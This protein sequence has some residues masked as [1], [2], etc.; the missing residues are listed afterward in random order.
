MDIPM[1]LYNSLTKKVEDFTPIS[2]PKVSLYVCGVT[3]YDYCHLGH[4]RAYVAFDLLKRVLTHQGYD[5][6]HVQNVTDIDD[7]IIDR[8]NEQGE[9]IHALTERFTAACNEDL[10]ALNILPANHMPK[11]TTHIPDMIRLI[12]NLIQKD[13]A[14]VIN[15]SVYFRIKSSLDYG[16]LSH[17]AIDDLHS[18][19][20][21]DVDHQKES[22]LDFVLWKPAKPDEPHWD[23]P[24]GMG[25][26]GW[27]SE[28]VAM[29]N[30]IL[31]PH[32]DIHGG[33]ADLKFPHHENELAQAKC[34][35][36]TP[37][38]NVWVHNGFVTI[39]NEKMSKSLGNFFTLR[40]IFNDHSPDAVRFFLMRTHYR[41]PLQYSTDA[42]LDATAAYKKLTSVFDIV[43][44]SPIPSHLT[45]LFDGIKTRFWGALSHDLNASEAI[46]HLFEL[47]GLI[48]EYQCG[49]AL[50]HELGAAIGLFYKNNS[51][52]PQD[53]QSMAEARWTAKKAKNFQAA[54]ELRSQIEMAGYVVEDK[55]DGYRVRT[56]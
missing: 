13:A 40:D 3:V 53:I 21:I 16:E 36:H 42:L 29:V 55:P 17:K 20:R 32:I 49:T 30:A 15:N 8:A 48:H 51:E 18:G 23:S 2:P 47:H 33:G 5:V 37:F 19:H 6:V 12:Q 52:I 28:C 50:L 34:A 44:N 4:A 26:P 25:R 27:H 46:S 43:P 11:A 22:P 45:P 56:A 7:K 31:G 10:A 9:D 54:D 41:A 24:W 14:Y 35:Y 38:A 1:K 39:D